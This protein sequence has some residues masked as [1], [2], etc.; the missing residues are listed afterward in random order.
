MKNLSTLNLWEDIVN[1][2][3]RGNYNLTDEGIL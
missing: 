2:S 1:L 3:L